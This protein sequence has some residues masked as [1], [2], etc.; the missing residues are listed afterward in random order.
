MI[1][2]GTTVKLSSE[3]QAVCES[4]AKQRKECGDRAYGPDFKTRMDDRPGLEL[5]LQGVAGEFA[6]C[7]LFNIYPDFT[8]RAR[9]KK[10]G[11]DDGDASMPDGKRVDIKTTHYAHGNLVVVPWAEP[12]DYLFALMVGVFPV[13]EFKGFME[14]REILKDERLT[15]LGRGPTFVASQR[16]LEVR[17]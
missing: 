4:I 10:A 13:Y 5:H 8:I 7:K 3:E 9:S 15:D 17:Y 11:D 16:E 2:T 1:P 12:G 14:A 6:F